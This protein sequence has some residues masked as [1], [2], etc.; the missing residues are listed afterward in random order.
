[1]GASSLE[2]LGSIVRSR[3]SA[4]VCAGI[5]FHMD[6]SS[7]ENEDAWTLRKQPFSMA[8]TRGLSID[9]KRTT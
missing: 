8:R 5:R 6:C 3:Y 2:S 9:R 4:P 1:M 7:G